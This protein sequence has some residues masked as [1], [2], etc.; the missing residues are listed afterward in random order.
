MFIRS[1][2]HDSPP[3]RSESTVCAKCGNN[4]YYV[5]SYGEPCFRCYHCFPESMTDD[6]LKEKFLEGLVQASK[7]IYG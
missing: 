5:W 1:L 4:M 7:E 3:D 6:E 2:F